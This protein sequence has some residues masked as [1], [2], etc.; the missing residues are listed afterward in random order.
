MVSFKL[1]KFQTFSKQQKKIAALIACF[2]FT[3]LLL[4]IFLIAT[5]HKSGVKLECF[6]SDVKDS[7]FSLDKS[8]RSGIIKSGDYA[9]FKFTE[10]Q[11]ER[12]AAFYEENGTLA[13][14]IRFHVNRS[15][16]QK[17][18]LSGDENLYFRYG[19]L[20]DLKE[21]LFATFINHLTEFLCRAI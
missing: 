10:S 9:N 11:R 17:K 2:I 21:N 16:V 5:R 19:F 1:P 14:T 7:L 8:A 6:G 18:I 20:S 15:H 12:M 13:I 4:G 3:D